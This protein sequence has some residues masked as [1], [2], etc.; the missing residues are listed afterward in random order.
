[1]LFHNRRVVR[2]F[3]GDPTAVKKL[4]TQLRWPRAIGRSQDGMLAAA[5]TG[6]ES[7]SRHQAALV[8]LS[9][10]ALKSSAS[11]GL[12]GDVC[13]IAS[14]VLNVDHVHVLELLADGH[15][16]IA[17]AA[18][19]WPPERLALWHMDV[20]AESRVGQTLRTGGIAVLDRATE[21]SSSTRAGDLLHEI[22][23]HCGLAAGVAPAP[24]V[25]A[26]FG[27]YSA[28]PRRFTRDDLQFVRAVAEIVESAL[29]RE[30]DV[31]TDRQARLTHG[32]AQADL[33]RII[34]GRLRPALRESVGHLWQFRTQPADTFTFR[35]AVRHTERQVATVADFIED[36]SLLAELLDGLV[37]QRRSVLLAPILVSLVDQ[38]NE[39][40]KSNNITLQL[41]MVDELV[42]TGGDAALLRRA[43]FNLVDNALRFTGA[44]G[45]VT[46]TVTAPDTSAALVEITD[47][48]RGMTAAQL[49]RLARNQEGATISEHRGPS[50]GWR[51]ASA[52]LQAHGGTVTATSPGPDLGSTVAV[53][54]PRLNLGDLSLPEIEE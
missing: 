25:R 48:G 39:R 49:D 24:D 19:G 2:Q 47:T 52:I 26:I 1:L 50:L 6:A 46:I 38:L 30:A 11:S 13:R 51:L 37:P 41:R 45:T 17:R 54:V 14:R 5:E 8:Y 36:L 7:R 3:E 34:V 42:A 4:L 15:T 23:M 10:R 31:N 22:R 43:L 29:Q 44:E 12:L 53:V 40:A 21:T 9:R 32:A 18:A 33:L 16:L 27:V 28:K 20:P 35:R